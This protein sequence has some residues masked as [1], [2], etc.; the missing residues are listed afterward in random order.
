MSVPKVLVPPA[1]NGKHRAAWD[2]TF[3]A[4]KSRQCAPDGL[5]LC[6]SDCGIGDGIIAD[7]ELEQPA[8]ARS[9]TRLPW[10]LS[11]CERPAP[12]HYAGKCYTHQF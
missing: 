1:Q 12:G 7:V 6:L 11:R 8:S 2:A 4:P 5:R 10:H 9:K 3:N